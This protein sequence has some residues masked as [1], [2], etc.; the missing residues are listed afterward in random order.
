MLKQMRNI[1]VVALV[2]C[3]SLAVHANE[4]TYFG[5]SFYNVAYEEDGVPEVNPTALGFKVGNQ[6]NPNFAI[7][8]RFGIGLA[9]D[10]AV[11]FGIPVDVDVDNFFGV[12]VKGVAPLSDAFSI[13]GLLG[14]TRGELT[15]SVPGT[16]ISVTESDSDLSF[17]FGADIDVSRT[18]A[19]NL[20][21]A[22]L[23]EGDGY[24]VTSTSVGLNFKF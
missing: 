16:D 15:A 13:Y 6:V 3:T 21:W 22:K 7:E 5:V 2:A 17:G 10:S 4:G 19:V 20:E 23:F 9:E 12:Y 11:V 14:Y 8:G 1:L 18:V 24:E